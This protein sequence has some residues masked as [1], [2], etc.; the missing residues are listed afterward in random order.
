[1][2]PPA[3]A[4]EALEVLSADPNG[5]RDAEVGQGAAGAKAINRHRAHSEKLGCLADG[6][7]CLDGHETQGH[8]FLPCGCRAGARPDN[9]SASNVSAAL[10]RI[11]GVGGAR[12]HLEFR[13]PNSQAEGRGFDPR[14]PLKSKGPD[15]LG[16][17]PRDSG[18]LG[19]SAR[20]GPAGV[21]L[22]LENA[23]DGAGMPSK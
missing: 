20:L 14:L 5:V 4:E 10:E 6:Q 15:V 1:M 16:F 3:A 8:R 13:K 18:P 11:R 23:M 21:P 2:L 19:V 7:Q 9:L 17:S 22:P 12:T